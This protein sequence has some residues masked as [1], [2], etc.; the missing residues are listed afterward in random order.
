MSKLV[1]LR[2][3]IAKAVENA[4]PLGERGQHQLHL[5]V[6]AAPRF[7]EGDDAR[8]V[9]IFTNLLTNAAR[10]TEPG[11]QIWFTAR[12]VDDQITIA[13]RDTGIGIAP[14]LLP[15]VFDLFDQ[16]RQGSDRMTGGLGLGLTL[17]RSLVQLHRGEIT[18]ASERT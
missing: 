3:P 14:E 9:Q 7:V 13:V 5:D 1:E 12:H 6:P 17:V 10:Y 11:G 18:A 2:D 4:T 15:R 8:R 16:G